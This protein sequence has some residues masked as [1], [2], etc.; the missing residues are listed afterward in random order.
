MR[1]NRTIIHQMKLPYAIDVMG[2]GPEPS[3][4]C[5]SEDHGPM[6]QIDPPYLEARTLVPGPGGCMAIAFNPIRTHELYAVMNC[7]VG[8]RFEDGAIYRIRQ[9]SEIERI[10]DLPFA[11]RLGFVRRGDSPILL[12]ANLTSAKQDPSDWSTPGGIYVIEVE[13]GAR[14]PPETVLTGIHKNHGF[15]LTSLDGG[16]ILLVGAS[17]GLLA[18]DLEQPGFPVRQVLPRET[19]EVAVFDLDGDGKTELTTIEPFH[20]NALRTYRRSAGKWQPVWEAELQF[21]HC[22]LAGVFQGRRSVLVS[23]RA[24]TKDLLLFQFVDGPFAKPRR[25]VVDEGVGAANMLFVSYGGK[26]HILAANQVEGQI[27]K[28]SPLD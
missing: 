10:A 24:G 22:V 26:D 27:V 8:Y 16:R 12:A 20:G 25:I 18:V 9:G 11:H 2:P 3:V 6:V 4:A 7:F 14:A 15:L 5:A 13:P 17:E 28:Y 1:F 19:S 23:N 21:G